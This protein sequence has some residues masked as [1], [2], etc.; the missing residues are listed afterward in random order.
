MAESSWDSE[1]DGDAPDFDVARPRD[2]EP[3]SESH[4]ENADHGIHTSDSTQQV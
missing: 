4:V 3:S 2:V 1:E